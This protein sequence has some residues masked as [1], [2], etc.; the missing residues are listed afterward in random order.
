MTILFTIHHHWALSRASLTQSIVFP[1]CF[2]YQFILYLLWA[3][4]FQAIP[5]LKISRTKLLF[6]SCITYF[7]IWKGIIFLSNYCILSIRFRI[8]KVV[9]P[10]KKINY[11]SVYLAT[12]NFRPTRPKTNIPAHSS[13]H[14]AAYLKIK[15][16]KQLATTCAEGL[17]P[18]TI[19][20]Y[21]Y[22]TES[23]L[24]GNWK[25]NRPR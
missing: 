11:G 19:S 14:D 3:K 1:H 2:S 4:I 12:V 8:T 22:S 6:F 5:S 16:L 21:N 10:L 24:S 9:I 18:P 15:Q 20:I 17:N 25:K 7:T 13:D 23:S